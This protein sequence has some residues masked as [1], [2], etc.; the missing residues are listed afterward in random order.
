MSGI[1]YAVLLG[2]LCEKMGNRPHVFVRSKYTIFS[3]IGI[4]VLQSVNIIFLESYDFAALFSIF[5]EM[6]VK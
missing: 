4:V 2:R 5:P 3:Y 1:I 6:I